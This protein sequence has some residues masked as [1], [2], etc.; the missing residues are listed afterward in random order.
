MTWHYTSSS[1]QVEGSSAPDKNSTAEATRNADAITF[2]EALAEPAVE[3]GFFTSLGGNTETP[4]FEAFRPLDPTVD[5]TSSVAGSGPSSAMPE[6]GMPSKKAIKRQR[7]K[8]RRKLELLSSAQGGEVEKGG[9]NQGDCFKRDRPHGDTSESALKP[10]VKKQKVDHTLYPSDARKDHLVFIG[11]AAGD[12]ALSVTE[13]RQVR[14]SLTSRMLLKEDPPLERSVQVLSCSHTTTGKVRVACADDF[15]L[16]WITREAKKLVPSSESRKEFLV[17]GSGDFPPTIRCTAWVPL[18]LAGTK[19]ELLN[20]LRVSNR[21]VRLEG[22]HLTRESKPV[23]EGRIYIFAAEHDVFEQLQEKGMRLFCGLGRISFRSKKL[24]E[25]E[26]AA[27][28]EEYHGAADVSYTGD[29]SH[30]Y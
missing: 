23:N 24:T 13:Y 1:S 14:Q 26:D 11:P 10:C 30:W 28:E 16:D 7:Q 27:L 9:G 29:E 19:L 20:L 2:R 4:M 15:T 21:D 6:S 12:P 5:G 17:M 8:L 3:A 22:L 25:K 18:D